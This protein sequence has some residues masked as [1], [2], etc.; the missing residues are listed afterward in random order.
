MSIL[1]A[2][3]YLLFLSD[4][5]NFRKGVYPQYKALRERKKRPVILKHFK[6]YLIKERQAI[7]LPNLE[8]DD[9][10]GIY[11]TNGS[12][13]DETIIVSEDKDLKTI[14]GYL[15]KGGEVKWYSKEDANFWHLYQTLIGDQ[16]DGYPGCKGIG[17][18]KAQEALQK[19]PTW[20]TVVKFFEANEQ[21]EE[22][23]LVQARCAR[24][25]H[26]EDWDAEKQE[27]KLWS[28]AN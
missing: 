10:I 9:A 19:S 2:D 1:N 13:T 15:Y 28:P 16:T 24:I 17:P 7:I 5:K 8:G 4:E 27:V 14:P 12:V 21:T 26:A 6:E 18:K 22:D 3:K 20:E 11:A 23:A 25:L